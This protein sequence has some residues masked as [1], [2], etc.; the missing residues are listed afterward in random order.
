[1]DEVDAISDESKVVQVLTADVNDVPVFGATENFAASKNTP[2]TINWEQL[3]NNPSP[4][5][6]GTDERVAAEKG[7]VRV[8]DVAN[9]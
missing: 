4:P 3:K 2:V 5:A 1:M 8:S 7:F 9:E 6:S